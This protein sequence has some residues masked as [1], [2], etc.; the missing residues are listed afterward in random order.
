MLK[1]NYTLNLG[2]LI[3]IT[4]NLKKYLWQKMK[5]DKPQMNIKAINKKKQLHL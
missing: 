4:P 1:T 2:H 5:I 3:K